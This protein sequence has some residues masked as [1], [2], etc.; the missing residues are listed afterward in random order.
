MFLVWFKHYE[1]IQWSGVRG[2][3]KNKIIF[4]VYEYVKVR[5]RVPAGL[6]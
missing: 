3:T 5:N 1:L 4:I 6:N 2:A